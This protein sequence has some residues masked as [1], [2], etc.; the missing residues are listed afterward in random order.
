MGY[1]RLFGV[2]TVALRVSSEYLY[3]RIGYGQGGQDKKSKRRM[4]RKMKLQIYLDR[5]PLV[6]LGVWEEERYIESEIV[7]ARVSE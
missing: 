6:S 3:I 2:T 5:D 7:D 4:R 1:R